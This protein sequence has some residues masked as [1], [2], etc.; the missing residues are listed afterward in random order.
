MPTVLITGANRGIGLGLVKAYLD[1]HWDVIATCRNPDKAQQ[2]R[3]LGG[4][5]EVH[6]LDV[7]DHKAIDALAE[8]LYGRAIDVLI[9]NAGVLGSF[10]FERGGAGQVLGKI[11]YKGLRYTFEVNTISPLKVTE[12]LVPNLELGSAK[13][14]FT[15][16]SRMGAIGE[17]GEGFAAYRASKAAV[18]ALMKNISHTLQEKG[19]AVAVVHPGWVRTDMGSQDA[20]LSIEQSVA[21]IINVIDSLGLEDTG[22]F[23]SFDGETI[24]W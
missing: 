21:G 22:C 23:K 13:K 14:V 16:T 7:T 2:L 19:I 9:N 20:P 24:S 17:M 10:D 8:K 18:N 4:S 6:R 11:D 3:D 5:V 15:I 12:V 1:K